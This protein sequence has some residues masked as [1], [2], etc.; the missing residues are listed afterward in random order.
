MAILYVQTAPH[1]SVQ[2]TTSF[3][4]F[5]QSSDTE[6]R[7]SIKSQRCFWLGN[8]LPLLISLVEYDDK[9]GVQEANIHHEF[10][11]VRDGGP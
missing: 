4:L 6:F 2:Q 5:A 8:Y 1:P 9:D 11:R 7:Q 3:V 10:K